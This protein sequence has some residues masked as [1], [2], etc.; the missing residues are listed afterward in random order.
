MSRGLNVTPTELQRLVG[1]PVAVLT[2]GVLLASADSGVGLAGG[3]I[4]L[5]SG[6]DAGAR[7]ASEGRKVVEVGKATIALGPTDARL[8][9]GQDGR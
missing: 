6:L 4:V 9:S 3:I 2:L 8:T 1:S 7:T 5:T